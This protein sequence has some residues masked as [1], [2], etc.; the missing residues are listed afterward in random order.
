MEMEFLTYIIQARE[1]TS[2]IFPVHAPDVNRVRNSA[3]KIGDI[4]ETISVY[5][6]VHG[7][8]TL[9]KQ[10]LLCSFKECLFNYEKI[11]IRALQCKCHRN[12]AGCIEMCIC[13][14]TIKVDLQQRGYRFIAK[15]LPSFLI[16]HKDLCHTVFPVSCFLV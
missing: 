14:V 1:K 2:E 12:H 4:T 13:Y 7:Y 15:A 8:N 6:T 16:Q 10:N 3:A 9:R 11:D 5:H